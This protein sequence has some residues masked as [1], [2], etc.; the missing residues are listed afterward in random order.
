MAEL[1]AV[2]SV[3][4]WC[5][6]DPSGSL[7]AEGFLLYE[8]S[9]L[10]P[11]LAAAR[12]LPPSAPFGADMAPADAM[13]FRVQ[14]SFREF[15]ESLPRKAT[16]DERKVFEKIQKA[17]GEAIE[18]IL[19]EIGQDFVVILQAHPHARTAPRPQDGM[20]LP[21]VGVAAPCRDPLLLSAQLRRIFQAEVDKIAKSLSDRPPTLDAETLGEAEIVSV[22]GLPEGVKEPICPDFSP[23]FATFRDRV[24]L[25]SARPFAHV[26]LG[27]LSGERKGLSAEEGFRLALEKTFPRSHFSVAVDPRALA[28]ALARPRY[29]LG[30]ARQTRPLDWKAIDRDIRERR[31]ELPEAERQREEAAAQ[32]R[33]EH[34][35]AR[36]AARIARGASIYALVRAFR[37][38]GVNEGGTDRAPGLRARLVLAFDTER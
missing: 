37:L 25:F 3:A 35:Q 5:E 8:P 34:E 33:V 27:I 28:D 10:D 15:W 31:G 18:A 6:A 21:Y 14:R 7:T 22:N 32:A 11:S 17:Y 2:R 4:G 19:P 9:R 20:P 24:L 13:V 26:L 30:I 36:L 12:A 16:D 29:S 23:G 1:A 38:D